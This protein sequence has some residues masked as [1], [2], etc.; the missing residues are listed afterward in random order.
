VCRVG[1]CLAHART[2]ARRW[3]CVSLDHP[4]QRRPPQRCRVSARDGPAPPAGLFTLGSL[5]AT[6]LRPRAGRL[7]EVL[8][9]QLPSV[10]P[11][12]RNPYSALAP[13]SFAAHV[14]L[15]CPLESLSET[16][17]TVTR[18]L[19]A[20]HVER[21][22][23]PRRVMAM[24]TAALAAERVRAA[25]QFRQRRLVRDL[26][27]RG[28]GGVCAL[29][30]RECDSMRGRGV[31]ARRISLCTASPA[32]FCLLRGLRAVAS[33]S[34]WCVARA[35][36][37]PEI[38]RPAGPT[39]TAQEHLGAAGRRCTGHRSQDRGRGDLDAV[40]IGQPARRGHE[41][42]SA[43]HGGASAHLPARP[44]APAAAHGAAP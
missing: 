41:Q 30:A 11:Y 1:C 40:P 35:C 14:E 24:A 12:T 7:L 19:T 21:R 31:C 33:S 8:L 32:F 16:A 23:A 4:C 9:K 25:Q 15:V 44:D 34:Y 2:H 20:V 5:L 42:G 22:G 43:R 17:P 13:R 27:S 18:E 6:R 28:G 37:R 36:S 38:E 3:R 26:S 39:P 29:R 10:L